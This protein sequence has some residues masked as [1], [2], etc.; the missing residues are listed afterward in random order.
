MS[1][2]H[3]KNNPFQIDLFKSIVRIGIRALLSLRKQATFITDLGHKV[4]YKF[5]R[6]TLFYFEFQ[7]FLFSVSLTEAAQLRLPKH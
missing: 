5:R 3:F 1:R 4:V 7:G 6:G 2:R